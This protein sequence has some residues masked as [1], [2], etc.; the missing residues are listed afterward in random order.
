MVLKTR[1]AHGAQTS[2]RYVESLKD[3]REVWLDG[4]RVDVT[5]HPAFAGVLRELA[6]IYDLQHTDAYRDQ[7]TYLSPDTGNRVSLS[8][9][10]PYTPDDL[11][12]RRRNSEIWS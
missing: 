4:E 7:M 1:S 10:L 5:T 3:G 11:L 2:S 9:L 6:R 8:Y 12:A